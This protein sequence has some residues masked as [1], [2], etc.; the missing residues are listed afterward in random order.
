M[1]FVDYTAEGKLSLDRNEI[2]K[3]LIMLI[4]QKLTG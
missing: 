3:A 2:R 4:V 1:N